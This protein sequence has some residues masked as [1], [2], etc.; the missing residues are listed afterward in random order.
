MYLNWAIEIK[1]TNLLTDFS[2]LF[3][4]SVMKY[5]VRPVENTNNDDSTKLDEQIRSQNKEYFEIYDYIVNNVSK[6]DQITILNANGQ[7][8]PDTAAQ[9]NE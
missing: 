5:D 3:W 2:N 7:V 8:I 9:V 4:N 1:I 6:E